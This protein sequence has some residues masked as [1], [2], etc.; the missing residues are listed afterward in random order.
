MLHP[1]C[2]SG[3]QILCTKCLAVTNTAHDVQTSQLL[4]GHTCGDR[5][6]KPMSLSVEL[7]F[8]CSKS[9]HLSHAAH[10]HKSFAGSF[11]DVSG[12][13]CER[14]ARTGMAHDVQ[15]TMCSCLCPGLVGSPSRGAMQPSL[16]AQLTLQSLQSLS[17]PSLSEF[18]TCAVGCPVCFVSPRSCGN[19]P[20]RP[21]L[22]RPVR[23][24][25][26][27]RGQQ[28][29]R[30]SLPCCCALTEAAIPVIPAIP[31][32]EGACKRNAQNVFVAFFSG[33]ARRAPGPEVYAT[34]AA[35]ADFMFPTASFSASS[36]SS[37]G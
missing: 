26:S 16:L 1:W 14:L 9:R 15:H 23:P 11:M 4:P 35:L 30:W 34:Y 2:G 18:S 29:Q 17:C 6:S 12:A 37:A 25:P 5:K 7:K 3:R 27:D 22:V 24:I 28:V 10:A 21:F 13:W 31:L 19:C 20:V 36:G 32:R 8:P 33:G